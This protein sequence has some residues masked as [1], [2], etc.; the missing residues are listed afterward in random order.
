MKSIN[1]IKVTIL[2]L[3]TLTCTV[4]FGQHTIIFQLDAT[5]FDTN[6]GIKVGLRGNIAPL[7]WTESFAMSDPDNDGIY[8]AKIEFNEAKTG[9]R[10]QYKY[11]IN[12]KWDN[13]R[14][15]EVGNRVVALTPCP[16]TNPVDKWNELDQFPMEHLIN[17][18]INYD[19][20]FW[21]YTLSVGKKNGKSAE[22][23]ISDYFN[24]WGNTYEGI[25]EPASLM[26]D[27]QYITAGFPNGEFKIIKNTPDKVAFKVKKTRVDMMNI[28]N[29]PEEFFGVTRDDLDMI[30]D[31]YLKLATDAK[32]WK[33]KIEDEGNFEVITIER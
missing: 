11:M 15:G 8:T 18:L 10:L 13:D 31:I 2:A 29:M 1:S 12:D 5:D 27:S 30:N 32:R 3:A 17:T 22:Q 24:F 4:L 6:S 19:T 16:L 21:V 33:L 20:W 23:A 26:Y 25:S 14:F 9:D 7:S 28:Y